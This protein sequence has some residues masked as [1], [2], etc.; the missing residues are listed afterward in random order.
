MLGITFLIICLILL[1]SISYQGV[2]IPVNFLTSLMANLWNAKYSPNP[3]C[4]QLFNKRP[5]NGL[6]QF[7]NI[8]QSS[9]MNMLTT[10]QMFIDCTYTT[11]PELQNYQVSSSNVFKI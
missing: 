7:M 4:L 1:S 11:V 6:F 10:S 2:A 3:K 5:A 8:S 9:G